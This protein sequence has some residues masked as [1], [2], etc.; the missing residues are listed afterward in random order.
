MNNTVKNPTTNP[1]PITLMHTIGSTLY[2]VNI[3]YDHNGRE[4]LEAKILRMM[5]NDLKNGNNGGRMKPPQADW[6][7]E[8]GSV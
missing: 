2:Q 3:Y 6:L 1:E 4:S 8:R 7:P 5:K